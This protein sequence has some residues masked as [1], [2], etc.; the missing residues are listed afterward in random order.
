[1]RRVLLA[2]GLLV[3][4]SSLRAAEN[5]SANILPTCVAI[6]S[7]TS[8]AEYTSATINTF[9]HRNLG[10]QVKCNANPCAVVVNI[11][12][13]SGSNMDWFACA[14][15]TNPAAADA[16]G[17]GG[18]YTSLPRSYQYRIHIPASTFTSGTVSANFERYNQ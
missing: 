16:N 6:D 15:V 8:G 13:R 2:I 11:D 5:C 9:G 7:A 18:T 1:M 17:N 14:S 4:A 12:C 3:F 10:A